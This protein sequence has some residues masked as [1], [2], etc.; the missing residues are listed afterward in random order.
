METSVC[1]CVCVHLQFRFGLGCCLLG[2]VE[3]QM[4]LHWSERE[5]G[6]IWVWP[7]GDTQTHGRIHTH[8]VFSHAG[9]T[10]LKV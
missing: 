3:H 6:A 7:M 8:M 2:L 10:I 5:E 1:V 9:L 4:A